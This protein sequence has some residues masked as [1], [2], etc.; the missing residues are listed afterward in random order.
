M[1]GRPPFPFQF[2]S[3]TVLNQHNK[4]LHATDSIKDD[5]YEQVAAPYLVK[6]LR[7]TS[8]D[9]V[10]CKFRKQITNMLPDSM[11]VWLSKSFTNFSG[12]AHQ[13]CRQGLLTADMCR[14]CNTKQEVDALHVLS[15]VHS[16]F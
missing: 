10:D 6:K 4:T 3:P 2:N 11:H 15:C 1:N 12:T 5:I 13:L 16:I 8:L 14:M 7:I 9:E